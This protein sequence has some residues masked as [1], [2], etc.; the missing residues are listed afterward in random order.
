MYNKVTAPLQNRDRSQILRITFNCEIAMAALQ[1]RIDTVCQYWGQTP[2][3][4]DLCSLH[5]GYE[6]NCIGSSFLVHSVCR[7]KV[8]VPEALA[9]QD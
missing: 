7:D 2:I 3:K 5:R 4:C 8:D 9:F 6:E 1:P